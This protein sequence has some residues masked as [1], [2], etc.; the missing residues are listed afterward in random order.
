MQILHGLDLNTRTAVVTGSN[1]GIGFETAR[2]LA[3]HGCHVILAC[4]DI[5]KAEAAAGKIR[6]EKA[7]ARCTAMKLDLASLD[8]VREFSSIV[9]QI[10]FS[11]NCPNIHFYLLEMKRQYCVKIFFSFSN[12]YSRLIFLF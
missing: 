4:R 3:L 12:E 2:S 1:S 5:S 9:S 7:H 6:A 11:M 8:S 10:F